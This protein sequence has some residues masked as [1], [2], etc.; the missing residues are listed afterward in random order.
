MR[1][2]R[3]DVR[4][5][6]RGGD[7]LELGPAGQHLVRERDVFDVRVLL[8]HDLA[9]PPFVLGIDEREEVHH[10][11]RADAELLQALDAAPHGV[12]VERLQHRT[13]EVHT[14]ADRDAGAAP[15]DGRGAR[16]VRVPDL[17]LVAPAQFDLVAVT[18]GDE[19]TRL[20]AVHLDHR[21]VGGRGAV[22][23][24]VEI[25]AER[26]EREAE[27]LRELTEAVHHAARLVVE[28]RG[29]LVEDDLAGG[30]DTDDVGERAADVDS[31]AISHRSGTRL[32]TG[33]G[34]PVRSRR[35]RWPA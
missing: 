35:R 33:R 10:R 32:A 34:A 11:D 4:V 23:E 28:R 24:D 29:R 5:D 31:D 7:P 12:L 20:R 30:C 25:R 19:Q 18:F 9:G 1:D 13:L 3:R 17:F 26:R 14:L 21:V 8:E 2:A 27:P 22:H 15:G 6:E 16:I